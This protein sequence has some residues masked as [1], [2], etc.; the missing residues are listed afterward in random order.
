MDFG[1]SG[2]VSERPVFDVSLC[3]L[4]RS[5]GSKKNFGYEKSSP[6]CRSYHPTPPCETTDSPGGLVESEV[7][8]F[9]GR[10]S[11]RVSRKIRKSLVVTTCNKHNSFNIYIFFSFLYNHVPSRALELCAEYI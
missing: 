1:L 6:R 9:A 2:D 5:G 4:D 11:L 3:S 8:P 10:I 7:L